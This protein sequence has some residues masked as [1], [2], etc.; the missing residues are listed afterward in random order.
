MNGS[1]MRGADTV[2]TAVRSLPCPPLESLMAAA[3]VLNC[4]K[5][6]ARF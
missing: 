5:V 6:E 4:A 2:S 3:T 1:M